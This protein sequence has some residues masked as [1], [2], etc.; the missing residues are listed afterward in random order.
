MDKRRGWVGGLVRLALLIDFV[1]AF[2]AL[3]VWWISGWHALALL[4]DEFLVAAGGMLALGIIAFRRCFY[5]LPI[6]YTEEP[7]NSGPDRAQNWSLTLL[8]SLG[9]LLLFV[10]GG[11]F[12][13]S[14]W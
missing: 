10:C 11:V 4:G 6:V 14:G 8:L 1:V 5:R 9:S 13:L 3:L 12:R 7:H 2:A